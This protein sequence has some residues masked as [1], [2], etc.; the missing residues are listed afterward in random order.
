MTIALVFLLIL[1]VF[2]LF[3]TEAIPPDLVAL[4]VLVAVALFGWISP[5]ETLKSFA[6]EAPITVAAM[7]ILS[8]GLQRCG[9]IEDVGRLMRRFSKVTEVKLLLVL[10]AGVAFTSAFVN[11][12]PVVVALMPLVLGVA[13]HYEISASKLLIPLS[14]AAIF[15]GTCS[16]IGTSTNLVVSS[17]AR[18]RYNIDIGMFEISSVGIIVC[19]VG[20]LY[21]TLIGR[22]LLPDRESLASLVNATATREYTTEMLVT[23]DS[24]LVGKKLSESELFKISN[25]QVREITRNGSVLSGDK[26]NIVLQASD[27]LTFGGTRSGMVEIESVQGMAP[28]DEAAM[29]LKRIREDESIIVEA[30]V[31]NNSHF[32]RRTLQDSR[33]R[34]DYEAQV[35][36]I[37]RHG[38][39]I[40]RNIGQ[41]TLR[42]GDTLLLRISNDGI[43]RLRETPDLLLLS[44]TA[45]EGARREKRPIVIGIMLAV[46]ALATMGVYPISILALAGVVLMVLTRCLRMSEVYDSIDWRIVAMIVGMLSLG[47]AVE[48]TGAASWLVDQAM[49]VFRDAHPIFVLATI[50]FLAMLL[51]E[52]ISNNAVAILLTPIALQTA[53]SLDLQPMPFLIAIMFAASA[54]FST[55][56]GYQ[57]NTFVYGAGGY[58]FSDFLKVGV[59]LNLMLFIIVTL[60]IPIFWP[61]TSK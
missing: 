15:G 28:A 61:L 50:Y 26:K 25:L 54:S 27:R 57:T 22:H 52:L 39:N 56:I 4:G 5:A 43:D 32:A 42:F 29:G 20:I 59:P 31:T 44:D 34:E 16:L 60:V 17:I 49:G 40:T 3:L 55:P 1:V 36:A 8:A 53:H 30:V 38:E 45:V 19:G 2:I 9:A 41:V 12:T 51:T 46:V 33:L 23:P 11:N 37:H 18:S 13:R 6:N 47:A 35:L 21:M 48:N 10:M 14:Y 7:F 24:E 58:K